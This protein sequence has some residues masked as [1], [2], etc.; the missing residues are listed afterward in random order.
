MNN[1][2]IR[3]L[4]RYELDKPILMHDKIDII[5]DK[6]PAKKEV[7]PEPDLTPEEEFDKVLKEMRA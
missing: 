2:L 5:W 1:L 6:P 4:D 3:I 7:V